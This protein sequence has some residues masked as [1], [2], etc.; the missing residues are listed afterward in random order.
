MKGFTTQFF[1]INVNNAKNIYLN[2]KNILV[3]EIIN[4][5]NIIYM[6][7]KYK[8]IV[9]EIASQSLYYPFFII[10]REL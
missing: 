8:R 2:I 7:Q 10:Y 4:L 5:E 3:F 9:K 6:I 1:C